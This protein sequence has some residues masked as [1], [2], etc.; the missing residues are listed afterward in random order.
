MG[1]RALP[2]PSSPVQNEEGLREVHGSFPR[3]KLRR[4]PHLIKP[5]QS[6]EKP[7]P[8]GIAPLSR[9][10]AD[11]ARPALR[12]RNGVSAETPAIEKGSC[13]GRQALTEGLWVSDRNGLPVTGNRLL[14]LAYNP[15][16]SHSLS[17]SPY[18]GEARGGGRKLAPR[19]SSPVLRPKRGGFTGGTWFRPSDRARPALRCRPAFP[20]KRP[21]SK[22]GAVRAAGPD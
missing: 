10:R 20:Q 9:R 15:S 12:C 21:R 14:H 4:G 2:F 11:R 8:C 13:Q 18:T 1:G 16:A 6:P 3:R 17:T 22:R 5:P 7:A 19:L